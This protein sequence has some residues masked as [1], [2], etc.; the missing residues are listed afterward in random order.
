MTRGRPGSRSRHPFDALLSRD[1]SQALGRLR[2]PHR[3][4]FGRSA[5]RKM[6]FRRQ[7]VGVL[8]LGSEPRPAAT[9]SRTRRARRVLPIPGGPTTVT[10]RARGQ[11]VADHS[12]V[13]APPDE[14]GQIRA[15]QTLRHPRRGRV[16]PSSTGPL[17][18]SGGS[19]RT[20][21]IPGRSVVFKKRSS[22]ALSRHLASLGGHGR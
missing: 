10:R 14:G 22:S 1:E 9:P 17:G 2:S 15:A 4:S 12:H 18:D 20:P 3:R 21:V 7:R 11:E 19:S 8:A 13:A 16:A 6:P 5:G